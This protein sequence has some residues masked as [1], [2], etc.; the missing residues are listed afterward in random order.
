[1]D[2]GFE[3]NLTLLKKD[4][5]QKLS[6]AEKKPLAPVAPTTIPARCAA[7][8]V[9]DTVVAPSAPVAKAI[10]TSRRATLTA[11]PDSAKRSSSS[12]DNPTLS[13]PST[14]PIQ[15]GSAP[16]VLIAAPMRSMHSR[17]RGCGNPWPIT[18]VSSATTP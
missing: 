4:L 7:Q 3:G 13:E 8:I 15:A 5:I 17:L 2:A 18:L 12:A 14:V 6:P 16:D 9:A 10:G 1:M 11:A